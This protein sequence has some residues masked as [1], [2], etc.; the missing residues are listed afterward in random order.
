MQSDGLVYLSICIG[1][2]ELWTARNMELTWL[3]THMPKTQLYIVQQKLMVSDIL[4]L[5]LVLGYCPS[6]L[7][8]LWVQFHIRAEL[9]I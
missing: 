2:K 9:K 3:D 1:L 8:W 6:D 5:S 7:T 4:V